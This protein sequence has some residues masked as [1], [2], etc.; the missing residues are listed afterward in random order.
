MNGRKKRPFFVLPNI[1]FLSCRASF[2][3]LPSDSEAPL[4]SFGAIKKSRLRATAH[5]CPPSARFPFCPPSAR[6]PFCPPSARFPFCPPSARFPF[7]LP[8]ARKRRGTPHFV[9]D[10]AS[11]CL[12]EARQRRGPPHFVR[13]DKK[14]L[15][16]TVSHHVFPRRAF[17]FVLPRH[18]SAEGP[19]G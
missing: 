5:P 17:L 3:V 10:D 6:F 1:L 7:C 12:P 13:G 18:A 2:F 11:G 16:A 8:E 4:T 9:Q 14:G 19:P 15:R